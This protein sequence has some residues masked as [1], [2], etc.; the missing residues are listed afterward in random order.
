VT[1][2]LVGTMLQLDEES[3]ERLADH[4]A[5]RLGQRAPSEPFLDAEGAAVHLACGVSRVYALVSARRIPHQR[6]GSRL[7]FKASELDA[8]VADGG[9]KRP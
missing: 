5:E 7:L 1:V 4:V 3:I 2:E 6:D 9:A 8:W